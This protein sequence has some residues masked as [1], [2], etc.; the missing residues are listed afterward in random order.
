[1]HLSSVI[2]LHL[3]NFLAVL[4]RISASCRPDFLPHYRSAEITF[5]LRGEKRGGKEAILEVVNSADNGIWWLR[6]CFDYAEE[7]LYL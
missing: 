7:D 6:E 3:P 2:K 1:M 5:F 4:F